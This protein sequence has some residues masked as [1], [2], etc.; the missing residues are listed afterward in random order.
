MKRINLAESEIREIVRRARERGE[1]VRMSG[2]DL[3]SLGLY[4]M[5]LSVAD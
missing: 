5:D 1:T 3:S 2:Y 4:E